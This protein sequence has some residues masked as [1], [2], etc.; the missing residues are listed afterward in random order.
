MIQEICSVHSEYAM[1]VY[2]RQRLR[3]D[4]HWKNKQ[5]ELG[6]PEFSENSTAPLYGKLQIPV[7]LTTFSSALKSLNTR[8]I[9]NQSLPSKLL[10]WIQE[11]Y[12]NNVQTGQCM[13]A[14]GKLEDCSVTITLK[15]FI[16]IQTK[17]NH[18][19]KSYLE[20]KW[21]AATI[22]RIIDSLQNDYNLL[23]PSIHVFKTS[24]LCRLLKSFNLRLSS[25]LSNL[26]CTSIEV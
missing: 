17:H 8:L 19:M 21:R 14:L 23:E 13:F 26:M 15:Q 24:A 18:Y 1:E 16:L 20:N 9:Y 5:E 25:E 3:F 6:L 22:N 10:R 12:W 4:P 2:C 11:R 7:R